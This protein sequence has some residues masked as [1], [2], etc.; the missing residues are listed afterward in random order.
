MADKS[1][2]GLDIL[3]TFNLFFKKLLPYL[4]LRKGNNKRAKLK[5]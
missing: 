2:E 3:A 5:N 1:F 4:F